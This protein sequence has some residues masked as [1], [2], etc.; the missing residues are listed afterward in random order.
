MISFLEAIAREEGWL[1]PES[2]AR[3]NHN[4]GNICW[5]KFA[6]IHGASGIENI[7]ENLRDKEQPRFAYFKNDQSGFEAMSSLLEA[8]YTGLTIRQAINK[9]APSIENNT[10]AYID[11]VCKWTGL[12]PETILTS[13]LLS[14]PLANKVATGS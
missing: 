2:R 9:W 12:T 13:A 3:R 14:P 8:S 7:P 10:S 5:G 11:N 6:L 4:P 1:V